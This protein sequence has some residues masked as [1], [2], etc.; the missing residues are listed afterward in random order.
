M[1]V[2]LVL[3]D[4][5]GL[6]TANSYVSLA[7]AEDIICVNATQHAV[8]T[9]LSTSVQETLLVW[10]SDYLDAHVDWK[11]SKAVKTSGLRW[12]RDCVYDVDDILIEDDVVPLRVKQA[13]VQLAIFL[14]T[15]EAAANFGDSGLLPEGI[16][17]VKADVVEVEFF[18]GGAADARNG[19]N[20]LPVN[21]KYLIRGLGTVTTGRLNTAKAIR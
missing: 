6:S 14:N 9:G 16:K 18:D 1:A 4:G 2:T 15:S 12:P 11:G 5:T 21:L 7:E 17:R 10:A 13:T 3:E 19:S 8:W 20:M